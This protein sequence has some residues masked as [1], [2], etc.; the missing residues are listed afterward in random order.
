MRGIHWD[1]DP[2]RV[3]EDTFQT[4]VD[5]QAIDL[6]GHL[7]QDLQ[8]LESQQGRILIHQFGGIQQRAGRRR[9]FPSSDDVGLGLLV[10][11]DDLIEDILHLPRQDEVFSPGFGQFETVRRSRGGDRLEDDLVEMLLVGQ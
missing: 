5:G 7:L 1:V 4:P 11:H 8:L 6:L 3:L 9:L 2:Y 10:S